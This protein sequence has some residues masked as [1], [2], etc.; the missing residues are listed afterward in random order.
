MSTAA[1]A[2]RE[3]ALELA[4]PIKFDGSEAGNFLGYGTANT[5]LWRALQRIGVRENDRARIAV[6]F[7]F[8][9]RYAPIPGAINVLA[10][11]FESFDIEALLTVFAPAFARCD[12]IVVPSRWCA[13]L[14]RHFTEKPIFVVPLGID[15]ELFPYQRRRWDPTRGEP[16]TWLVC[17]A[18]NRRKWTILPQLVEHL[19]RPFDEDGPIR[20]LIKTTG[21]DEAKAFGRMLAFGHGLPR[22]ERH[23][24]G[25]IYRQGGITVDTRKL[26]RERL[27]AEVYA[28]AH[29]ALHLHAGEGWGLISHEL[30]ATGCPLVVT[31]HSGTREF[32]SAETAFPVRATTRALHLERADGLLDS[33]ETYYGAW[34]DDVSA[35]QQIGAVMTNYHGA[36]VRAKRGSKLA[37]TLTWENSARRLVAAL[38]PL[39]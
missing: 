7:M 16:F 30:L 1:A 35:V 10:T 23:P 2:R 34:P 9:Q 11:M 38:A 4:W 21:T 17:G 5:Q 29:A 3:A 39:R 33:E 18:P 20:L 13:D 12:A 24:E 26:P 27:A 6:H 15:A 22:T 19:L 32:C 14:F 37:H 31:D 28:R 25:T 8:P 36:L